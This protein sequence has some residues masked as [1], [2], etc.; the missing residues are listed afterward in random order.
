MPV[1]LANQHVAELAPLGA[2]NPRRGDEHVEVLQ[3]VTKSISVDWMMGEDHPLHHLHEA[4]RRRHEEAEV[5]DV[6]LAFTEDEVGRMRIEANQPSLGDRANRKVGDRLCGLQTLLRGGLLRELVEVR[7]LNIFGGH[8]PAAREL[9]MNLRDVPP[10]PPFGD[11]A[12][13]FL[14]LGLFAEV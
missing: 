2:A 11:H 10:R 9:Q 14:D 3:N 5:D 13:L 8:D 1:E 6:D 4:R 12:K 7:P